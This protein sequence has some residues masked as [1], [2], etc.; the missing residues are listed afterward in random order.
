MSIDY[1]ANFCPVFSFFN[2]TQQT[3]QCIQTFFFLLM[4]SF[5]GYYYLLEVYFFNFRLCH[6]HFLV[7][8]LNS[9]GDPCQVKLCVKASAV[10]PVLA[11]SGSCDEAPSQ[12]RLTSSLVSYWLILLLE[13]KSEMIY[14]QVNSQTSKW[15]ISKMIFVVFLFLVLD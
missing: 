15:R 2:T 1:V 10:S 11:D 13:V 4:S 5:W 8:V 9:R 12:R 14:F 7:L 3:T 6:F